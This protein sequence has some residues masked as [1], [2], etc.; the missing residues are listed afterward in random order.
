EDR[1]RRM[2]KLGVRNIHG[3]NERIAKAAQKGESLTRQVQTGFDAT[4]GQP[5]YEEE[6]IS[7]SPM[8]FIVV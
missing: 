3:Y 7:L 2:S 8:P 5:Q 6:D 4:T 1:Y